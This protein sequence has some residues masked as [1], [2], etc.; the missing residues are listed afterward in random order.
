MAVY[1]CSVCDTEYSEE[2]ED[3]RWNDLPADWVCPV[4]DS[5]KPFWQRVGQ[6]PDTFEDVQDTAGEQALQFTP[7]KTE[8]SHES[9]LADIHAMA[10]SGKSIIE[11]MQTRKPVISWQDILIQGAQLARI[12][13]NHSE[14]VATETVIGPGAVR[15]LV[16]ATPIYI[17]H[18]SFGALS[19]EAKTALA[20]GR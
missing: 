3:V 11:P 10:A 5:S 20:R 9:Y 17:S 18:M 7:T 14:P 15:P 12:P 1:V 19:K 8:D 2:N 4:C 16:I 6:E 13:L